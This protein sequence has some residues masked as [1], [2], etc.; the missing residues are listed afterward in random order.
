[1]RALRAPFKAG[2]GPPVSAMCA[3][4]AQFALDSGF[5]DCVKTP[6]IQSCAKNYPMAWHTPPF[7][8]R[9]CPWL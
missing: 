8:R 1:M 7:P 5:P 4:R 3:Y 9:A 6:K 2:G